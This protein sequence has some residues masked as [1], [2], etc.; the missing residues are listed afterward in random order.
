MIIVVKDSQMA[1]SYQLVT[2]SFQCASDPGSII[3]P[4]PLVSPEAAFHTNPS[5]VQRYLRTR[6]RTVL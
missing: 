5:A 4:E 1:G 3:L 6:D 2:S